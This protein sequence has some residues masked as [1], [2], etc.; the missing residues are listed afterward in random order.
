MKWVIH[1]KIAADTNINHK[2]VQRWLKKYKSCNNV[3]RNNGSG[4]KK[5]SMTIELILY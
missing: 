4:R 1:R 2:T 5:I 3:D